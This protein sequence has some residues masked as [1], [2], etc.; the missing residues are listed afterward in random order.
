MCRQK[1]M[2][3]THEVN[4][5]FRKAEINLAFS[6]QFTVGFTP[7]D[8]KTGKQQGLKDRQEMKKIISYHLII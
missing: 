4:S 1:Y 8:P 2:T 5:D 6:T 7:P 3:T